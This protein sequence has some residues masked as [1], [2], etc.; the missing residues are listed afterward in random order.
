MEQHQASASTAPLGGNPTPLIDAEAVIAQ[1]EREARDYSKR[2]GG[3]RIVEA[4]ALIGML[5]VAFTS[6]ALQA[7]MLN[8]ELQAAKATEVA[9]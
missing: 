6:A 5:R 1:C 2:I 3:D 8:T 7:E 4:N 9:A